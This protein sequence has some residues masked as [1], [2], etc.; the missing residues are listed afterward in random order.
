M[1]PDRPHECSRRHLC[2]IRWD[3]S[4]DRKSL[5]ADRKHIAR[6]QDERLLEVV[7][8]HFTEDQ[9]RPT[10]CRCCVTRPA[11]LIGILTRSR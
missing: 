4:E 5:P 3:Y 10:T 8:E 2:L 7:R 6:E 9:L 11:W 1:A